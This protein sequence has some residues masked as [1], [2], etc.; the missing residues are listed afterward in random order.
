MRAFVALEVQAQLLDAL[1]D[2]QK[3]LS[4]TGADM[5]IVERQN[6]HFTLKFLG[7]ISEAQALEVGSRLGGL[8]LKA[9]QVEVSGAGAFPS[10]GRPRV[11]WAGVAREH[12]PLVEPI[13][14]QVIGALEGI[15][16]R[17][18]RPFQAHI[19]LGRV[20]S[21][22]NGRQ[23]GEL[24][25]RN[26]SRRFGTTTLSELKLKSSVLTSGGPVYSD[27]GVFRLN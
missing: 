2:F 25:S 15:G 21:D 6:L 17:D 23:L 8:A 11:I 22:R 10:I 9:V 16:E 20:R 14:R 26:S 27:V 3:E 12:E 7:E 24:L 19:T 4:S 5:K 1:V 18:D 13:A